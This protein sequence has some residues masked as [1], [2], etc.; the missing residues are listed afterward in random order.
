MEKSPAALNADAVPDRPIATRLSSVANVEMSADFL[1]AVMT[2]LPFLPRKPS[3]RL[4]GLCVCFVIRVAVAG[5]TP[6]IWKKMSD[7]R[8]RLV[9][10]TRDCVQWLVEF[11]NWRG[12]EVE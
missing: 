10:P 4:V 2:E 1:G 5:T 6:Q 3:G 9:P 7:P 11:V 12:I 8:M